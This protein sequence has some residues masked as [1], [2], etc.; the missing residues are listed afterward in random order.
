MDLDEFMIAMKLITDIMTGKMPDVPAS[1]PEKLVP[2]S[3]AHL[4][5][6]GPASKGPP[7]ISWTMPP[8]ERSSYEAHFQRLSS[9][10]S[11]VKSNHHSQGPPGARPEN[12]CV[13][14]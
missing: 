3:K 12:S 4:V 6:Q 14:P 7:A 2:P 10:T 11:F 1:L 5:G 9:G 8:N 13:W